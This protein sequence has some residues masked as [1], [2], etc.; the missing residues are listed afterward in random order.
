M[1]WNTQNPPPPPPH[2]HTHF[3]VE[4]RKCWLPAHF[5]STNNVYKRFFLQSC[6]MKGS[7]KKVRISRRP[8]DERYCS[9]GYPV[10]SKV[11]KVDYLPS[12]ATPPNSRYE[13]AF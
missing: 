13:E 4:G 3:V 11:K 2:T 12:T 6:V 8:C 7:K 10:D 5:S 9:G 1:N